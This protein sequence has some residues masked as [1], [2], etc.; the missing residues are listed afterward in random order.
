VEWAKTRAR[1]DR[2][3]EEVSLVQE[4][5]RR[6]SVTLEHHAKLWDARIAMRSTGI[7]PEL[8]EGIQ[9]YTIKQA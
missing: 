8:S 5:M 9:A 1:K 4:E 2:W 3:L 6:I 7:S